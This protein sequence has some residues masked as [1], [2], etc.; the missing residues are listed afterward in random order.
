MAKPHTP[1]SLLQLETREHQME[2]LRD[3]GLYRHLRFAR[4]GTGIWRFD[5]VTW[6]GHLVI[7]G[8]IENF[9]FARLP[10]MFEFF[11]SPPGYIN[12]G[13]WAEKLRGPLRYESHSPD[14]VKRHVYEAFRDSCVWWE[15]PKA[16]LWRDICDQ[17]LTEDVIHDETTTHLALRDFRH[18]SENGRRFEF[19]DTWEWR[20][21]EYD[22]HFLV[23]LHAIVW[24]ID[25]YDKAR[26]S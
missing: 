9:H 11:R 4:P 10:D 26:A 2:V 6:P 12:P 8:D 21:K 17:I 15:D 1:L 3:D 24:G 7:T 14:A 20:F 19:T 23:S 16:P 18:T 13:Y 22:W 5:L 25:Q